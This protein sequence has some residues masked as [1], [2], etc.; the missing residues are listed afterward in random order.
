MWEQAEQDLPITYLWTWKNIAGMS[1]KIQG[2]A[3][4]AD[5]MIRLQG[6]S[7]TH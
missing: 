5:G 1:V 7:M 6:L 3:P 4:I 2:F